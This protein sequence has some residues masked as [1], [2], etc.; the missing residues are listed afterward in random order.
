M[1]EE[2]AYTHRFYRE[3]GK[4]ETLENLTPEQKE[5]AIKQIEERTAQVKQDIE[6]QKGGA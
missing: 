6:K 4:S 1:A 5:R 3:V 2:N